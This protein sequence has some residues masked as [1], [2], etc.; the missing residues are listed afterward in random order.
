MKAVLC[1]AFGPWSDLRIEEVPAPVAAEH[2]VVIRVAACGVNYYDGLAAEGKYQTK[3]PFPFAPG[4][5]VAGTIAGVGSAVSGFVAGQKVIAFTGF[6]GYA[7][8]VSVPASRVFA[9]PDGMSFDDAA[10]F[11]IAYATSHHALKDRAGVRAG[12]TVL[13]LGAAGGVGLT[14]VE[15]GREMGARVIAAASSGEKLELARVSG[16]GAGIDY[17]REDLRERVKA[18][19]GGRGVDVV[20]DPVGGRQGEAAF[21]S[22]AVNGRHLVIGFASGD[23]PSVAFNQLLLRQVSVTGVLWGAFARAEPDRAAVNVAELLEWHA[24]GRLR[25][26]VSEI[27]PL[28]QFHRALDS[29]MNRRAKGKVVIRMPATALDGSTQETVG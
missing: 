5:E 8:M 4:G 19:T 10:A 14:A 24:A 20:Y 13:V 2:E 3:P 11:L 9:M 23:I 16:A 26:H 1:H 18:L 17:S 6:G 27:H 21:K 25:P 15:I 22:L 7:E 29:V 12:E 28:E